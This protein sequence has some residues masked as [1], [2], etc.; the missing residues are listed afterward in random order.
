MIEGFISQYHYTKN[1]A[2][3]QAQ[4]QSFSAQTQSQKGLENTFHLKSDFIVDI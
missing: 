1:H 3:S 4:H 2:K